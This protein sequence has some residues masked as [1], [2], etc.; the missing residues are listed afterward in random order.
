MLLFAYSKTFELLVAFSRVPH[1]THR[2]IVLATAPHSTMLALAALGA[3]LAFVV[4]SAVVGLFAFVW[5]R[6]S[7]RSSNE[8]PTTGV[9]LA[10]MPASTF[11]SWSRSGSSQD[12]L[13]EEYRKRVRCVFLFP[14]TAITAARSRLPRIHINNRTPLEIPHWTTSGP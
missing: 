5:R 2:H 13:R 1:H 11:S 10:E 8:D 14:S 12:P 4:G 3:I 6:V 9:E 7:L